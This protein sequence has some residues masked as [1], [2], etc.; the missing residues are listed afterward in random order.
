MYIP[1]YL[2]LV[3][4]TF[5]TIFIGIAFL[6]TKKDGIKIEGI[7]NKIYDCEKISSGHGK[8]R[9]T[10]TICDMDMEYN[11]QNKSYET[12]LRTNVRHGPIF[13]K[14][15]LKEGDK[16]GLLILPDFPDTA[17][18][19]DNFNKTMIAWMFIFFG[20]MFPLF[21]ILGFIY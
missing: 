21:E 15:H 12:T 11:Y 6:M 19:D 10:S 16:I 4:V 2:K 20:I 7:I 3:L 17:V 9:T 5:F 13:Y 8:N 14:R 1:R 18:V